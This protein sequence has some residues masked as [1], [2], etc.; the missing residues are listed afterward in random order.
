MLHKVKMRKGERMHYTTKCEPCDPEKAFLDAFYLDTEFLNSLTFD[1]AEFM[2]WI[3]DRPFAEG[4][5]DV[6]FPPLPFVK[7]TK[8]RTRFEI[9]NERGRRLRTSTEYPVTQVFIKNLALDAEI[10]DEGRQLYFG[11]SAITESDVV[12][13]KGVL[14]PDT[15]VVDKAVRAAALA[16][17]DAFLR[18]RIRTQRGARLISQDVFDEIQKEDLPE[19]VL[20]CIQLT[21]IARRFRAIFGVTMAAT[22]TRIKGKSHRYWDGYTL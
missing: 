4:E 18:A 16:A 22:P 9:Q 6:S 5:V 13:G 7:S 11:I 1:T 3:S 2:L 17:L 20:K 10:I 14:V 21:D 15:E 8:N 12:D 19:D